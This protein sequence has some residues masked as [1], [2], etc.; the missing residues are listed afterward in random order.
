[1]VALSSATACRVL[2]VRHLYVVD[3]NYPERRK[4]REASTV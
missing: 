2:V 4:K 3:V 1:M